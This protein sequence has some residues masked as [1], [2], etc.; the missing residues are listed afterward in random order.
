M[1]LYYGN[2]EGWKFASFFSNLSYGGNLLCHV[3]TQ[4]N[5]ISHQQALPTNY[6]TVSESHVIEVCWTLQSCF[7]VNVDGSH[8]RNSGS[9]TCGDLVKESNENLVKGIYHKVG[10]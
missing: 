10:S 7:K 5:F 6:I 3:I 4:T 8:L 2:L 1:G 9:S